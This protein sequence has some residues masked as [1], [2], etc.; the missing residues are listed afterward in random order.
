MEHENKNSGLKN[1]V[2]RITDGY[3]EGAIAGAIVGVAI[4]A[5]M[6]K[7]IIWGAAIGLLGGGY[8]GYLMKKTDDKIHSKT[9][10]KP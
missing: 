3:K 1:E 7:N 2:K 5:A 10:R 8:V 4:A 9:K 6:K